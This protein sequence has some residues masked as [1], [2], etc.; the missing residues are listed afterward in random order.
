[1]ATVKPDSDIKPVIPITSQ[2]KQKSLKTFL[3]KL[4]LSVLSFFVVFLLLE[5][6][7]RLVVDEEYDYPKGLYMPDNVRG[8][9]LVPNFCGNH[10]QLNGDFNVEYCVDKNGY[11]ET[12]V[13][14]PYK[15][16]DIVF[17]GDSFTFGVGVNDQ[18]TT[19]SQ[20]STIRNE[21]V[22]NAGLSGYD[23]P[24]RSLTSRKPTDL[25]DSGG[26]GSSRGSCARPPPDRTAKRPPEHAVIIAGLVENELW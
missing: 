22:I 8:Q 7:V 18:E 4:G 10:S 12:G 9:W 1:M 20:L 16:R 19:A 2:M 17:I 15:Q 5:V 25:L 3:G 6:T 13:T 11:R 24:S 14:T 21:G 23:V 26:T